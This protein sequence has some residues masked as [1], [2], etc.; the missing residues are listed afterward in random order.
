MLRKINIVSENSI[1]GQ[2]MKMNEL[3]IQL[4]ILEKDNKINLRKAK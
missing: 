1:N 2:K 4:K 3:R